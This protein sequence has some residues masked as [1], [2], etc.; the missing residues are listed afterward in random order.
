MFED[1]YQ[2]DFNDEM[3]EDDQFEIYKR[4]IE[5]EFFQALE[6]GNNISHY[7]YLPQQ[8]LSEKVKE[9]LDIFLL[10]EAYRNMFENEIPDTVYSDSMINIVIK[11]QD[12][13]KQILNQMIDYFV[14]QE[15]FEKCA[16]I[17]SELDSMNI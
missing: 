14:M 4:Q 9:H 5:K 11:D 16:K 1:E 13:K 12:Y 3:P 6:T 8:F 17:K 2:E 15:E 10:K 7:L